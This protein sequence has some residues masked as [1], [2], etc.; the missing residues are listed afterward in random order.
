MQKI[1]RVML[2]MALLVT[3]LIRTETAAAA[4]A[5]TDTKTHW[6]KEEIATAVNQGWIN[7]YDVKT[8]KPN[9]NMTRAE[10]LK[11]L[12]AAMKIK[13]EDTDTPFVDDSGWFRPFI[14]TG[15]KQ[16]I[17]KVGD[18][19]ENTF[20]PNRMITRE[21]IARMTIRAIGKDAEGAKS[22]YLAVAKKLEIMKG[23]PDGSMG[24]EKNATRAEA[25]VMIT[26]TLTAKIGKSVTYPKTRDALN[27]MVQSLPNFNGTT[28]FGTGGIVLINSK[29]SDDFF[30]YT[31]AIEYVVELKKTSII[32]SES[33]VENQKVVKEILKY[34]FPKSI[35]KAYSSYNKVN[36]LE[37]NNA[38]SVID[39]KYDNRTFKVYKGSDNKTVMI[40]IGE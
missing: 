12:V 19:A 6:A 7:G 28:M 14:A 39:T 15:L 38:N 24:G 3:L 27:T 16:S 26:N 8:F 17:I 13:T 35:D 40:R 33:N 25:V 1:G 36:G 5:F 2:A 29:G 31:L 34:Y 22:G 23:Y 30:D 37:S 21:E 32:I 20:E 4:V 10:F 18:Y 9:A 11:S